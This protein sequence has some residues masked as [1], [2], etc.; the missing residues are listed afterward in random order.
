MIAPT[1]GTITSAAGVVEGLK[2]TPADIAFLVPSIVQ[3]L[4]QSLELLEYCS[5]NLEMIIYCGGDLPQSIGDVVASKIKLVNQFGASELGLTA[6]LLSEGSRSAEDWKYCQFHPDIGVELRHVTDDDFELYMI[7]DQK[8][9][10]QQPTFTIFPDLQEYA[11]RDLFVRHPSK[12]KPYLWKWRARAD[13]II[14]FL[15]GEKTN[16]ISMEQYIVSC[17]PSI[18]AV[19]VAGSQR[20]QAALLIEPVATGKE[21]STSE[22]A[23]F[24][25]R[26]WPSIETANQDCPAH[27][28]I[29]KTHILFT[30]LQKPML[31]AGKGTIQRAGTLRLYIDELNRLYADADTLSAR[32][33]GEDFE[34]S[35]E[36][37]DL[38][39]ILQFVRKTILSIT[40]WQEL[41]NDD[42]VF[43]LGM[44]SLQALTAVRKLKQGL[45]LPV[46]EL[47]TVY[48]NSSISKLAN[49]V[50]QLANH[51]QVS[52]KSSEQARHQT[53][54][55]M[56]KEYEGMIDQ[57]PIPSKLSKD[58]H[59][60]N[61]ILTGST[62]ALGS[63]ILHSLLTD[64]AVAHVYC[65]NRATD[66]LSLQLE[67]NKGR[68][69]SDQLEPSRVTFLKADLSQEYFG[70]GK[71]AYHALLETATL[72]I[73]NAW[74][75]N[76][77]LSLPSFRPH[78]TGLVNIF[79]FIAS[80]ATSPHLFFISSISSVFLYHTASLQTPEEVIYADGAPSSN[81]YGESKYLSERLIDYAAKKL[82]ISLSFARVGQ[83]AGAV[84]HAGLWNRAEW[85]PSLVI[86]SLHVGAI[87][88]SFGPNLSIV[89][90]VPIDLLADV[91]VELAFSSQSQQPNL[92]E[93]QHDL[94]AHS[95]V[96]SGQGAQVFHPLNPHPITWDEV[97]PI[98]MDELRSLA[99]EKKT[100]LE[101]VSLY[102]WLAK[103]RQ[104]MESIVN[105][106]LDALEGEGV[107]DSLL[108]VNPA[109]K[110]LGFYEGLLDAVVEK[111]D[112]GSVR[113]RLEITKTQKISE[114]FRALEGIR[115]EWV[116]KWVREWI[117]GVDQVPNS[118]GKFPRG[119]DLLR[120]CMNESEN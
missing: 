19:L 62:G 120:R 55:S 29:A 87:P 12:D 95:G 3:E 86:S 81:G 72:V 34:G 101:T 2:K 41:N 78:L 66:G 80:A 24:V 46:I 52:Q 18:A 114:K 4:S 5:Q 49:A 45:S 20:F 111:Q 90:W 16:P 115:E 47:T 69:L 56:L 112:S 107:L 67:R 17:N 35:I 119:P 103:V 89:D 65:L 8:R 36:F 59:S 116:R 70:L 9:L 110:L 84:K 33:D 76:F 26:I 71:Q 6:L 108:R 27:A 7:R 14:V 99:P 42:D 58:V 25:E 82:S 21:L 11:S 51:H 37:N 31:R 13:D 40:N 106:R 44:D 38:D 61:V 22:R 92:D 48:T 88:D 73:H 57:V 97:R 28:R 96:L 10:E 50:F 100:P 104:D 85:F 39:A 75:V 91:L 1:S 98:V 64:P 117:A 79:Q 32:L 23:A 43:A 113:N 109:I 105:G 63:Y 15:T 94:P 93:L 118:K 54:N 68:G 102:S 74:P 30:S 53:M 83:I 60:Q 77:N